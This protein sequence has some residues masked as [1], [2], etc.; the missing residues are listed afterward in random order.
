MRKIKFYSAILAILLFSAAAQAQSV[1]F[2]GTVGGAKFQM[3]L[4]REGN[5]LSGTYFYEKSGSENKLNL[6]GKI[7]AQ[8]NFTLNET[9]AAGKLTGTFKGVWKDEANAPGI[10]LEGTWN[11][12]RGGE[13]LGF[14]AYQQNVYFTDGVTLVSRR[15]SEN[16][17]PKMFEMNG[18]YP[19]ISGLTNPNIAKFN[20]LA[21]QKVADRLAEFKK[22]MMEQTAEDIKFAKE[23]GISNYI[24]IGYD[25]EYANNDFVSLQFIASTYTGGAHPN[26][27]SFTINYDLKNGRELA[28]ADLFQPNSNYLKAI[29]D[30]SI[31]D[32]KTRL[33]DMSDDDWIAG[34]AG[35]EAENC[36]SWNITEKGL[37][38]NFDPYQVAAYAA[39]PQTVIIPY[40][41]LKGLWKPDSIVSRF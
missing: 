27:F 11:R 22:D 10:V 7:D 20:A 34:G 8:G 40:E 32:L 28:L 6:K 14:Y 21:K 13:D 19:E 35:A 2:K 18:E 26:S 24:E 33:T 16:N 9:D 36:S 5:A 39:G 3:S 41:N 1:N 17:K 12:P 37:M 31:N 15:I 38:I 23:R 25:A 4:T 30:Y 29:S